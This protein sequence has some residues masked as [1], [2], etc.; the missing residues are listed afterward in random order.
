MSVDTLPSRRR[1]LELIFNFVVFAPRLGSRLL[2]QA[3]TQ[4]LMAQ[5]R[6]L[7]EA[8]AYLGEPLSAANGSGSRPQR[9]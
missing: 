9:I 4:P 1:A 2:A 5:V 8:M 6:R 7:V 3:E